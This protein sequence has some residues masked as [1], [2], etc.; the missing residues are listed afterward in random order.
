MAVAFKEWHVVCEALGRGVQD[1]IIRKGGIHE[2]RGGFEFTHGAFYLFPTL[3]HKQLD[4]V[5][6]TAHSWMRDSGKTVWELGEKVPV[7]Y[8]CVVT[9]TEV[10]TDWED[11]VAL[12]ARHVY[13]E[14]LVRERFEWEGKGMAAGCVN[15]ATV[16]VEKLAEPLMVT[17]QKSHGGCRSWIEI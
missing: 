10:L 7:L 13:S 1:V 12:S 8:R 5:K 15:F 11:V 2:G 9:K 6:E 16:E 4:G 3:F 17:Y 14:A